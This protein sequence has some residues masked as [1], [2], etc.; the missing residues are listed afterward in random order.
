MDRLPA[1]PHRVAHGL[2]IVNGIRDLIHWRTGYNWSNEFVYGL[3][4][5]S[6]FAY[7]R[8]RAAN[9]PRQVYW[10]MAT[11][12]QHEYLAQLLGAV[13]TVVEN[14]TFKFT[15]KKAQEAVQ[16]G[17]PP[18]LGPLDMY[19]LPYFEH[20][21]HK[22]HIPIHYVLLVDGG[23]RNARVHDTD[24][25][26][27]QA[28]PLDEL[29]QAW[30]VNIPAMGR[31]NR[32]TIID[33]PAKPIPGEAL[34]HRAIEDKC[35]TM[36]HP[37]VNMLGIPGMKK[38]AREITH[39]P[40]ELGNET[41]AACLRQVR[42]YLN[43]PPDI[44]GGHLTATRDLYIAFLQEAAPLLGLDFTK[45][46]ALLQESM[47]IIPQIPHALQCG[48][49]EEAAKYLDQIAGIETRAYVDLS[50]MVN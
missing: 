13:Y 38:L 10:G 21:Y 28:I 11:P 43:T 15:W 4:Q 39:W 25:E 2:C 6:G 48:N 5:G 36:L 32:L 41:T 42:E 50:E 17:T 20:I 12:R 22:W 30:N 46:V 16:A 37:P 47:R 9:P 44:R 19:H 49:L 1:V 31:K 29:E 27:V 14:R 40:Q 18:I 34:V 3:G 7:I 23:D 33:I 26:T 35:R 45:P 24:M 8:S